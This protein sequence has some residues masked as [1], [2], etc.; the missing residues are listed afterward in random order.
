MGIQMN[1]IELTNTFMVIS[2][3]KKT[4]DLQD[5]YTIQRF[6]GYLYCKIADFYKP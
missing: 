1:R 2:N 3:L 6:K 4:F 5:L